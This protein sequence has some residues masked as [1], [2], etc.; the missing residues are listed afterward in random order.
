MCV[1]NDPELK[2]CI[3]EEGNSSAYAMHPGGNKLY[4]NLRENFWWKGMKSDVANFVAHCL[5][6]QQVKVEHQRPAG[7]LQSLP[8]PEWKWEHITMDFVVGLPRSNKGFDSI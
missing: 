7:L 2:R 1:P 4:R 6:C 8:I 5:T 3:L